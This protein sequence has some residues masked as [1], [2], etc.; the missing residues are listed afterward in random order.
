[1][2]PFL[3]CKKAEILDI[4]GSDPVQATVTTG[5]SSGLLVI[6]PRE[7]KC[8]LRTPLDIRFYDPVQG[9]VRCRCRLTHPAISGNMCAYRCK[10]LEQ[11]FQLQRR[12]DI[13]V[14]QALR[15]DVDYEG[16]LF[17]STILNL[18]AGG[19]YLVSGLTAA[20]G[21]RL[22]FSF[23]KTDPPILL[24]AEVLR[25]ELHVSK[26]RN[27]YGYGCRFVDLGVGQENQLRR[28][29]F[30]EERKLYLPDG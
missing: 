10:V 1:M 22:T 15:V 28:Y 18:S 21:D 27:A 6:V 24:H 20:I 14:A 30:Q 12:E 8:P 7:I 16:V 4:N 29:V 11:I 9:I 5:S 23:P 13:K 3:N 26:E 17:P 25:A 2:T 19:V